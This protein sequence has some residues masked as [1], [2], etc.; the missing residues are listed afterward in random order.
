M[1]CKASKAAILGLQTLTAER[2]AACCGAQGSGEVL[3]LAVTL[4]GQPGLVTLYARDG[5]GTGGG[6]LLTPDTLELRMGPGC[7][8]TLARHPCTTHCK[9]NVH[10]TCT[11]FA[12]T[13]NFHISHVVAP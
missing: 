12:M 4:R 7:I 10:F 5:A 13:Y 3:T 9:R 2:P 1:S 6:S 8:F 11:A